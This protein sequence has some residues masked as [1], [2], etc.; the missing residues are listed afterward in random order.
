MTLVTVKGRSF[1]NLPHELTRGAAVLAEVKYE[2]SV[3]MPD[4][5]FAQWGAEI[6][7]KTPGTNEVE[8]VVIDSLEN[9]YKILD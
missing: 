3:I 1:G 5:T 8:E 9:I 4:G 7:C 6:G 2:V